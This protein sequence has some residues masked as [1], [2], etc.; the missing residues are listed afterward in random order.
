MDN[1]TTIEM[2]RL[3]NE[4]TSAMQQAEHNNNKTNTTTS[5]FTP[6]NQNGQFIKPKETT[7]AIFLAGPCPRKKTENDW[8]D[9]AINILND[10]KFKGVVF[11][12]TNRNYPEHDKDALEKQTKWETEQI[13]K[14]SALVFW[15]P[16][17]E[18]HPAFT[19]NIE[20]G[21]WMNRKG[22][23]IGWPTNAMKMQYIDER[24]KRYGIKPYHNLEEML[25]DV[26]ADLRHRKERY[27]FT[28]DTHFNQER[29]LKL[30][31]RPFRTLSDMNLTMMS[32]WNKTVGMSDVV[33]HAGDFG[34]SSFINDLNFHT[35]K[36][37]LGNYERDDVDDFVKNIAC[38][39]LITDYDEHKLKPYTDTDKTVDEIKKGRH[40]EI[41]KKCLPITLNNQNYLVVH[42]P[43]NSALRK[44][45][46]N[47]KDYTVLFGHI[48]GRAF[49]K[50]N[51]FDL[52]S[53]YHNYTPISLDDV[54][55]FDTA[56][57]N[58][59]DENVMTDKAKPNN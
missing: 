55:W 33:V 37:V 48:H 21:E 20:L 49:A 58:Y 50:K 32:N 31:K 4:M 47:G 28:S 40:V 25:R 14:S 13:N 17:S 18:K 10:L 1:T 44:D 56:L 35:L 16:R 7:N 59:W 22:V 3:I 46:F 38:P 8:R 6:T 52:A 5:V 34:D 30:S 39:V 26:V 54:E 57:H 53:D 29:T 45:Y 11:N 43:I 15:V 27:F 23:Y 42:E 24:L 12:P 41:Y 9:N 51:G 36:F 19:T 2:R